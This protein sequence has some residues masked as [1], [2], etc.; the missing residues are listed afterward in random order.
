MINPLRY[1]KNLIQKKFKI[2]L[3]KRELRSLAS[4]T[5]PKWSAVGIAL[6]ESLDRIASDIER[7]KMDL[8]EKRR[9]FL[10]QSCEEIAVIDYG[11]GKSYQK[12]TK[13]EMKRGVL[14]VSKVADVTKASKPQPWAFMLFKII[15]S[16]K[17]LSSL[18]LGSCVG[19]SASY[20]SSALEINEKGRLISLEGSPEIARIAQESLDEMNLRNC[21]IGIGPFH[22]TLKDALA[23]ANPIDF[24]F[25]D[26]HHDYDAVLQYYHEALPY[27]SKDAVI[28]FDDISWS[29][30]M[31][32]A[33]TE[34]EN[35]ESVRLSIDLHAI[36]IVIMGDTSVPKK[37]LSISLFNTI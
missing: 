8:I 37:K 19:I 26:G 4:H 15:R 12:R 23:N 34:I 3:E 24:L 11:A 35:K 22:D 16:L 33:W 31:R 10:L 2:Y 29:P 32:K 30:G 13:E 5:H 27:L 6:I 28:I 18:E 21:F 7:T 17:P 9:F 20:I 14:G 36:G 25:N 1:Y